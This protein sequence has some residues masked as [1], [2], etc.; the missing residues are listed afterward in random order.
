[1]SDRPTVFQLFAEFDAAAQAWGYQ[2]DQ[3]TGELL[4]ESRLEY[5]RTKAALLQR[6]MEAC[7][8]GA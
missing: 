6:L 4:Q 5:E 3:G 1:V 2:S 8:E 7:N